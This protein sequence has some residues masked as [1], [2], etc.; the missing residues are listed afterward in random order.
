MKKILFV[1]FVFF[2]TACSSVQLGQI[3]KEVDSASDSNALVYIY[4]MKETLRR[5]PTIFIDDI[6]TVD[7][8]HNSYHKFYIPSG[9]HI[10]KAKWAFDVGIRPIEKVYNLEKGKKYYIQVSG[11]VIMEGAFFSGASFVPLFN[12]KGS[13]TEMQEHHALNDLKQCQ[14]VVSK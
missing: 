6:K 12:S 3:F 14:I 11:A 5:S 1:I 7:L 8:V 9:E 2:V 10:I 4:R 13:V